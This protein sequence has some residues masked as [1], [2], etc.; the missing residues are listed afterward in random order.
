M[1]LIYWTI[2]AEIINDLLLAFQHYND[3]YLCHRLF[4][5]MRW[6]AA[7]SDVFI[8]LRKNHFQR[9]K[10]N[11]WLNHCLISILVSC[12]GFSHDLIHQ[13]SNAILLFS[14]QPTN[15]SLIIY[16]VCTPLYLYNY[17]KV[18]KLFFLATYVIIA[19]RSRGQLMVTRPVH[20]ITF[21]THLSLQAQT[22]KT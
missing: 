12:T 21:H 4:W 9:M 7:L 8:I 1:T 19:A 10:H 18:N 17:Y 20:D 11:H 13:R 15:C 3:I 14:L 16:T 5:N 6:S 22:T 2:A